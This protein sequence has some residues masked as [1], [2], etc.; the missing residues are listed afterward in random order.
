MF[1]C[2]PTAVAEFSHLHAPN[3]ISQDPGKN[4]RHSKYKSHLHLLATYHLGHQVPGT[5]QECPG[6]ALVLGG[7]EKHGDEPGN[8]DHLLGGVRSDLTR[9]MR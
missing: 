2:V 5:Q 8:K 3:Y 6:E 9:A 7:G 1:V 4:H